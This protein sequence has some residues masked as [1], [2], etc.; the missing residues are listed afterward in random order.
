MNKNSI[1]VFLKFYLAYKKFESINLENKTS[2]K[3]IKNVLIMVSGYYMYLRLIRLIIIERIIGNE[4]RIFVSKL[5]S[6]AQIVVITIRIH[7]TPR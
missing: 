4:M 2:N 3:F 5:S 7:N 1:F 6:S